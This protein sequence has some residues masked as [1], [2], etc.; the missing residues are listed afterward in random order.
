MANQANKIMS[1]DD[2]I[3]L[4]QDGD[5]LAISGFVGIGVPDELIIALERRFLATGHPRDLTLLFAAAPGDGKDLGA[6]RLAHEGMFKRVIGGHYALVPRLAE[7]A[8]DN[9]FEAYNLPLGSIVHLYRDIAARRPGS[10]SKVGLRTFVDPRVAGGKLN[11]STVEDLVELHEVGGETWL[12]YKTF[13]I[14]VAMIRGTTADP[15][16]NITMER[17]ALTLD[18]LCLAMATRNSG[19][20]VLAQVERVAA[21]ETLFAREVEIPGIL[22]DCVVMAEERNHRQTYAVSYSHAYSGRQRVPLDRVAPPKMS[23]RKIIG[24]R[25][26]FELPLGGIVNLGIGVPESLA[27]V[28]AEENVLRLITL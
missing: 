26:A 27:A 28:A 18:G 22:V 16:G 14:H 2:A 13:P 9:K 5:T 6:N 1:A 11:A 21:N 8:V 24:R 25:C 23:E 17:E 20:V 10:L 19:G 7:M 15:D 12:F 4:I 3:A